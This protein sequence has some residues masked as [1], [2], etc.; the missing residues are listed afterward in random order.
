MSL[1]T[2]FYLA[3]LA[4]YLWRFWGE[5]FRWAEFAL[6]CAVP[7]VGVVWG[8]EY[9]GSLYFWGMGLLY[10][11]L[12]NSQLWQVQGRERERRLAGWALGAGYLVA[13]MWPDLTAT[14]RV[15]ALALV[16]GGPLL[17]LLVAAAAG[18][19]PRDRSG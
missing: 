13:V 2:A 11:V 5:V 7:V 16:A 1:L 3:L 8:F 17:S 15:T 12:V 9:G 14:E 4:L 10:W 19:L 6:L 18:T